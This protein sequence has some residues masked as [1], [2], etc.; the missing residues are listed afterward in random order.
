MKI[1]PDYPEIHL[2]ESQESALDITKLRSEGILKDR[3]HTVQ[4]LFKLFRRAFRYIKGEFGLRNRTV[5]ILLV[6]RDAIAAF[7]PAILE[8]PNASIGLIGHVRNTAISPP[9]TEISFE[10][11]PLLSDFDAVIVVDPII[12][13]G[14]TLSV[15]LD[16]IVSQG[17][18]RQLIVSCIL[19]TRKAAKRIAGKADRIYAYSVEKGVIDS[20]WLDPGL[21]G[22]KDL[23]DVIFNTSLD[24][25]GSHPQERR[26]V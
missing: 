16:K 8:L 23:G 10:R 6:L 2:I 13:T 22:I 12:A 18:P 9:R 17:R 14:A 20:A 5:E 1:D 7:Y 4:L 24:W 21:R 3:Q 19:V 11:Y 15:V 25:E 26:R